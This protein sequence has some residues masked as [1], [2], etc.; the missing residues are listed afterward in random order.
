MKSCAMV[1]KNGMMGRGMG[2]AMGRDAGFAGRAEAENLAMQ[3]SLVMQRT[4]VLRR[5]YSSGNERS[6]V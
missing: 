2:T 3:N 4:M 6:T 5:W 1:Q